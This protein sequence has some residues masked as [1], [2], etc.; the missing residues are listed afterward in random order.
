M[1]HFITESNW[2]GRGVIN[3]VARDVS[4]ALPNK[5]LHS[6]LLMKVL[7]KKGEK[8]VGDGW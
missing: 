1:Q 5:N 4:N 6:L 3:Q 8:I 7:V 2:D